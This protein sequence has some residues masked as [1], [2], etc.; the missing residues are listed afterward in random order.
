MLVEMLPTLHFIERL[1]WCL[2]RPIN[3]IGAKKKK[4]TLT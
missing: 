1:R 2:K 3:V 4:R